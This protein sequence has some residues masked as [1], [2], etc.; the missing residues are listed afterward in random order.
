MILPIAH[1]GHWIAGLLYVLP[2][3]VVVGGLA[4]QAKRDRRRE[5]LEGAEAQDQQPEVDPSIT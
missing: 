1:A 2:L 3:A 5:A 4:F